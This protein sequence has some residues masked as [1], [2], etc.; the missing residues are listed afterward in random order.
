VEET[1][2]EA[3]VAFASFEE[4]WEPFTLGVGPA[5]AHAQTLDE[6]SRERLRARCQE[7]LPAPPFTLHTAAW[8]AR[9]AA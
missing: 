3:S 7:L 5:G 8:A 9:G 6:H 4:W 2:V 1:S